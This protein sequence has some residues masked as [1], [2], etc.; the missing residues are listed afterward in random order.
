MQRGEGGGREES[1][2]GKELSI[3]HLVLSTPGAE[4]APRADKVEQDLRGG[5]GP[6]T[7]L[8]LGVL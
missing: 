6:K 5:L 3:Q 1:K 7:E 4:R 2:A 8:S